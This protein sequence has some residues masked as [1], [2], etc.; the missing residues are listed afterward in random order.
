[1][2]QQIIKKGRKQKN[3]FKIYTMDEENLRRK[4]DLK[5]CKLKEA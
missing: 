1:M 4:L 5:R 3:V 2:G